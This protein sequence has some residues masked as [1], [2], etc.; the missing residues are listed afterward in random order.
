MKNTHFPVTP[1]EW[2][3]LTPKE[4]DLILTNET[5]FAEYIATLSVEQID[6]YLKLLAKDTV[7]EK[8]SRESFIAILERIREDRIKADAQASLVLSPLVSSVETIAKL[9][10]QIAGLEQIAKDIQSLS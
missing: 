2:Q 9:D 7:M 8:K 5:T 6:S 10:E 3:K 4:V 1:S